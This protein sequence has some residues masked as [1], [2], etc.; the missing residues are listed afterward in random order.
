MKKTVLSL[1]LPFVGN[2]WSMRSWARTDSGW[3]VK[4][5]SWLSA[6]PSNAEETA[7]I[8]TIRTIQIPSVRQGWWLLALAIDSGLI[9]TG[10]LSFLRIG[11]IGSPASKAYVV[12][13]RR[14]AVWD[15][16]RKTST[17]GTG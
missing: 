10:Q 16:R 6:S 8:V 12:C 3:L 9:L 17:E 1:W 13:L 11:P 2:F 7:P 14:T 15:I 5:M 4:A